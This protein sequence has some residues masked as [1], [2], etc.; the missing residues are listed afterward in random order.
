[1]TT[2]AALRAEAYRHVAHLLV[3]E[4]IGTCWTDAEADILGSGA[5]SWIGK[6]EQ[7]LIDNGTTNEVVGQRTVKTGLILP[8]SISMGFDPKELWLDRSTTT[9]KLLDTDSTLASLFATVGKTYDVL[10]QYIKAGTTALSTSVTANISETVNPRG[11][12]VGIE[13]IGPSG[14]RQFF[15]SFPGLREWGPE[16]FW[17]RVAR[18]DG[19][20]EPILVSSDLIVWAGRRV[21]LYRLYRDHHTDGT[22][23]AGAD[24][25]PLWREQYNAGGLVWWGTLTGHGTYRGNG[26]WSLECE[27]PD[28]LLRKAIG[29]RTN[30][31]W[32]PINPQNE[33]VT[34]T[35]QREDE[36]AVIFRFRYANFG[37]GTYD[38]G[39]FDSSVFHAS[40]RLTSTDPVELRREIAGII[41]ATGAGTNTN[42]TNSDGTLDSPSTGNSAVD[43]SGPGAGFDKTG[44][45]VQHGEGTTN[46]VFIIEMYLVLHERVWALLGYDLQP[47][48]AEKPEEGG[49]DNTHAYALTD[50]FQLRLTRLQAGWDP[51]ITIVY[52]KQVPGP[53]YVMGRFNAV[54]VGES[55]EMVNGRNDELANN[56]DARHYRPRYFQ[57]VQAIGQLGKQIIGLSYDNDRIYC[58]GNYLAQWSDQQINGQS[59]NRAGY[60]VLRGKRRVGH[61]IIDQYVVARC[62]WRNAAWASVAGDDDGA[63]DSRLSTGESALYIEEFLDARIFGFESPPLDGPWATSSDANPI[64]IRPLSTVVYELYLEHVHAW[65]QMV[66]HGTGTATSWSGDTTTSPTLD[67]GDNHP[68]VTHDL[69]GDVLNASMSLGV[70]ASLVDSVTQFDFPFSL[71]VN[72]GYNRV[73]IAWFGEV[74]ADELLKTLTQPRRVALRMHGRKYGLRF[75]GEFSHEGADASILE[76]DLSGPGD[77]EALHPDQELRVT[78]FIDEIELAYRYQPEKDGTELEYT[79]RARDPGARIRAGNIRHEIED[80]GLLAETWFAPIELSQIRGGQTWA[81][82]F[83]RL[84]AVSAADFYGQAHFAVN[85]LRVGIVKGQ[86][87][88]PGTRIRLTNSWV[89]APDGTQGVTSYLGVVLETD[90]PVGRL[91]DAAG[92]DAT[93]CRVLMLAKGSPTQT[94]YFAPVAKIKG[95]DSTNFV[96]YCYDDFRGHGESGLS[97]VTGFA[98]PSWLDSS[99]SA[100]VQ[101]WYWDGTLDTNR[102]P[103]FSL[104]PTATVASV[105]TSAHT[106]TLDSPG[107]SFAIKRDY[108]YYLTLA[109]VD[110]GSQAQWVL[111]LY[112]AVVDETGKTSAGTKAKEFLP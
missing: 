31:D 64:E 16:H 38:E 35:G 25:W 47:Y 30:I 23:T 93:L 79:I 2:V 87:I 39:W 53:G 101:A 106:I 71:G 67:T 76:S 98:K 7:D 110:D 40:N 10:S 45:F 102:R 33:L 85:G 104:G 21:A 108:D 13:R 81:I 20:P 12:Y 11:K 15:D 107:F 50:E 112:S 48:N 111:D 36:I 96:V 66:L 18:E 59:V 82:D 105:D 27:G 51:N 44:I 95:Y 52:S 46:T 80:W 62:S 29:I 5:S 32:T 1:M 60:F 4:G 57:G 19:G 42:F 69:E 3:V 6:S 37:A 58:Q 73:R 89:Y 72:D 14:Q 74:Q 63:I 26:T 90:H 61:E 86:D 77:P 68:T 84:W 75:F 22:S 34:T 103:T 94:P 49:Q 8:E 41:E 55:E 65:W 83:Q 91:G 28:S 78:G 97:D 24:Q 99:G 92:S 43:G 88:Y 56:E 100:K 17:N 9:F 109:D 70:I 54:M